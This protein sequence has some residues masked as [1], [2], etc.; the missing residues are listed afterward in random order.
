M[1]NTYTVWGVNGATRLA[2][3]QHHMAGVLGL[4]GGL[5]EARAWPPLEPAGTTTVNPRGEVTF[6]PFEGQMAVPVL[7]VQE[8]LHLLGYKGG[9]GQPLVLDG[10]WGGNTRA[11]FQRFTIVERNKAAEVLEKAIDQLPRDAPPSREEELLRQLRVNADYWRD[12]S[13]RVSAPTNATSVSLPF[14]RVRERLFRM[15]RPGTLPGTRPST[16]G[17]RPPRPSTPG[18]DREEPPVI[19]EEE[20][21]WT[22]W[23][24]AGAGIAVAGVALWAVFRKRRKG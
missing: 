16:P 1:S 9:D 20:T 13:T 5:G 8:A 10:R 2:M 14:G 22:T 11:A 23:I 4:R 24:L 6:E 3:N 12:I 7:D 15:P 19:R 17:P 21:D 18:P